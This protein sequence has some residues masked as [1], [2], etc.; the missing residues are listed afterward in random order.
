MNYPLSSA[1]WFWLLLFDYIYSS[2]SLL[3]L[4]SD[5]LSIYLSSFISMHE[6]CLFLTCVTSWHIQIHLKKSR[7]FSLS[8]W[9]IPPTFC[10]RISDYFYVSPSLK[11]E[12]WDP[13]ANDLKISSFLV[14]VPVLSQKRWFMEARSSSMV[15]FLT[16]H[17][18][19]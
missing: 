7:N 12:T 18:T 14:R 5:L 10:F 9:D 16:L 2:I 6:S 11:N 1:A 13:I 19:I 3:T 15:I 4:I 8:F 17:P